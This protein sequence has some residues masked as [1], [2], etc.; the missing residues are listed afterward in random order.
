M[1]AKSRVDKE[2]AMRYFISFTYLNRDAKTTHEVVTV[3]GDTPEAA[4]AT[5][6]DSTWQRTSPVVL[7]VNEAPADTPLD[8]LRPD[9]SSGSAVEYEI[10][11]DLFQKSVALALAGVPHALRIAPE[12]E[13]DPV[14][15][16]A[17]IKVQ[18]GETFER[19]FAASLEVTAVPFRPGHVL[20]IYKMHFRLDVD[21]ER[22]REPVR[23][24]WTLEPCP[25]TLGQR[26]A[27][28]LPFLPVLSEPTS[29]KP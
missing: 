14:Q 3:E 26:Q 13:D 17:R 7:S 29:G 15:H 16:E 10:R 25:Y 1:T 21:P 4:V 6:H 12:R 23:I 5:F 27:N 28:R 9:H 24:D 18:R 22:E 20:E 2:M 8:T 19:T 11:L